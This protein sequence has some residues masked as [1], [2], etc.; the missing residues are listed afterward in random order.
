[1]NRV[2][3]LPRRIVEFFYSVRF[4][5]RTLDNHELEALEHALG[6]L[7]RTLGRKPR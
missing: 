7:E 5:R 1:L 2:S 6:E 3:H 4:G